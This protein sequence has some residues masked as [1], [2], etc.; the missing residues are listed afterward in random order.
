MK[1]RMVNWMVAVAVAL[2]AGACAETD[3]G[4]TT[5][6]KAKFA[7]DDTV[8][9]YQIDV[10]TTDKV[11]TLKGNV[12]SAAAKARAVEIAR[13]TDGVANVIDNVT[14]APAT[15]T[16]PVLPDETA[17]L[18]DPAI[19][20]AV[21]LKFAAD[22]TVSALRIDVD[23]RDGV[24]TLTGQLRSPTEKDQALKLARETSGVKS[25]VDR[26]TVTP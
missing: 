11:V 3:A 19:T 7:A 13:G 12:E 18:T 22:T 16:T 25:V 4:I 9:A 10:D 20:S 15:A 1:S 24:V 21:K 5:A 2:A 23:T 17:V 26:L 14:V 8:K 6:V